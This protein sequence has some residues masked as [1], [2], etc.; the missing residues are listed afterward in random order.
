MYFHEI[1]AE[2][3]AGILFAVPAQADAH[4]NDD[5]KQRGLGAAP[6]GILTMHIDYR[7]P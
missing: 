3:A 6:E 4:P 1:L 2:Y 7:R 5:G